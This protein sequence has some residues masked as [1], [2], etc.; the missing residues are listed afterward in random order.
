MG[1]NMHNFLKY[2]P[3]KLLKLVMNKINFLILTEK[4]LKIFFLKNVLGVPNFKKVGQG[5]VLWPS[6]GQV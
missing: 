1:A 5:F 3:T 4:I 6:F 2:F